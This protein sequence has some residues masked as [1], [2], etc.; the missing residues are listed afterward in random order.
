[1]TNVNNQLRCILLLAV[2]VCFGALATLARTVKGTVI[3]DTREALIGVTVAVK[4]MLKPREPSRILTA[5]TPS[6]CLTRKTRR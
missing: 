4:G 5:T 2:F 3:D 1:M 6:K